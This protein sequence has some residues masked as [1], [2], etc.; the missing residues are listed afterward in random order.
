MDTL[1]RQK[2]TFIGNHDS[3]IIITDGKVSILAYKNERNSLHSAGFVLFII[4]LAPG[5][6]ANVPTYAVVIPIALP[7]VAGFV[8]VRFAAVRAS[9]T[10]LSG[11]EKNKRPLG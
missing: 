3:N 4:V 11:Q 5:I 7:I 2:K 8:L 1:V 10:V 9:K 6:L